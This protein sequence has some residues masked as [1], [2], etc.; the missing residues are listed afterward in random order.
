MTQ[1]PEFAQRKLAAMMDP[2]TPRSRQ[3]AAPS[4]PLWGAVIFGMLFILPGLAIA[5]F[6]GV[7]PML[8][9]LSAQS[10]PEAPAVVLESRVGTHQGSE[11]T[12]YSI[13]IRFEY[14]WEG[15]RFVGDRYDFG[16]QSSSGR[17]AKQRVVDAFPPGHAFQVRVNPRNPEEAVIR[18]EFSWFFLVIIGFGLIFAGAGTAVIVVTRRAGRLA[19]GW[20]TP[21]GQDPSLPQPDADD[22]LGNVLLKSKAH[23][24]K[25]FVGVLI[26]ALVW[27]GGVSVLVF[28]VVQSWRS[29]RGDV[30][31]T[32]FAVPFVLV[33]LGS[34]IGAVVQFLK[35]LNPRVILLLSPG[36]P[37]PGGRVSLDWEFL[38]SSQ[39]FQAFTIFLEGVE[40]AQYRQG[41]TT[42]TDNKVF[43]RKT[44]V[45]QDDRLV[46]RAGSTEV[47]VPAGVM[48]SWKG[49][50]NKVYWRFKVVG[51]IAYWPDVREDY[52]FS[53][54]PPAAAEGGA[55]GRA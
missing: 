51:E 48:H 40:E 10:W 49:P 17:A 25:S 8:R 19:R 45:R 12:T 37:C 39:R 21:S 31:L 13:E 32:L 30:F 6:A 41:T 42:Y 4:F 2:N 26:F 52:V 22:G 54:L 15:Q 44:L 55:Y 35:A 38:G 16:P 1:L 33:G 23:P 36:S 53:V 20:L 46:I 3:S 34:A 11:S 7:L 28:Q 29:G 27:N 47:A 14:E 9:T 24:W 18:P 43:F 50:N 5:F